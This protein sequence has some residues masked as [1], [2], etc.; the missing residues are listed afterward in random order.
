V[1]TSCWAR[2]RAE[3]ESW[4]IAANDWEDF[5]ANDNSITSGNAIKESDL[6]D[7]FLP[8]AFKNRNSLRRNSQLVDQDR[9][10]KFLTDPTNIQG[11]WAMPGRR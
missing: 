9:R 7:K 11:L 5:G 2:Y 4:A 10:K 6:F 8:I 3:P 1:L